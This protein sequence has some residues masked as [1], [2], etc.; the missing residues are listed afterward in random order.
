MAGPNPSPC[1]LCGTPLT[2]SP[3]SCTRCDWVQPE[4]T[5]PDTSRWI[6]AVLSLIPGAGHFYKGHFLEGVALFAVAHLLILPLAVVLMPGTI[7]L[8]L[9]VVPLFLAGS[10][11]HAFLIDDYRAKQRRGGWGGIHKFPATAPQTGAP[12]TPYE[13]RRAS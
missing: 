1:P 2:E 6:A 7:G 12:S 3:H 8:S 11:A 4:P 10:M 13:T 9:L 5:T